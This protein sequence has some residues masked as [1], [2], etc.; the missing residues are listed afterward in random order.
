M[1]PRKAKQHSHFFLVPLPL[2]AREHHTTTFHLIKL[3]SFLRRKNS[4]PCCIVSQ[5]ETSRGCLSSQHSSRQAS[6]YQQCQD[7]NHHDCDREGCERHSS[8]QSVF[9]CVCKGVRSCLQYR[10]SSAKGTSKP[11]VQLDGTPTIWSDQCS[12]ISRALFGRSKPLRSSHQQQNA[13]SGP[14]SDISAANENGQATRSPPSLPKSSSAIRCA[15][16]KSVHGHKRRA[17]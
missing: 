8:F 14:L 2:L 17:F 5:I 12:R 6:Q 11:S 1:T 16:S 13:K 3:K 9:V 7:D 15:T 4:M 10:R